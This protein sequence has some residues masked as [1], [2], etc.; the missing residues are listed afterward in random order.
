M[1]NSTGTINGTKH[2][3][4]LT[5][6][7]LYKIKT[8]IPRFSPKNI[9]ILFLGG[10]GEGNLFISLL[11]ILHLFLM[12]FIYLRWFRRVNSMGPL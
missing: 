3:T 5:T 11:N 2:C 8:Y 6:Y 9:L 1:K 7:P 10:K 4:N 12:L